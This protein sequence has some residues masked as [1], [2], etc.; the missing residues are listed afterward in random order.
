MK[1]NQF[2][3]TMAYD[4]NFIDKVKILA[5]ERQ[6][7]YQSFLR[8]LAAERLLQIE[9]LLRNPDAEKVEKKYNDLAV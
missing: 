6:V 5:A 9:G 1:K 8:M 3:I 4:K 2:R 7:C